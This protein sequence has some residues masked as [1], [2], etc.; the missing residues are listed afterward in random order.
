MF[1]Q[2]QQ[3]FIPAFGQW[4]L[5]RIAAKI[6][7]SKIYHVWQIDFFIARLGGW[8]CGRGECG[9]KTFTHIALHVV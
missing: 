3:V 1:A 9:H 4:L 2:C 7:H 5:E 8:W 6:F